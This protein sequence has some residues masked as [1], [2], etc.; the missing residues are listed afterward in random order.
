MSKGEGLTPIN[1]VVGVLVKNERFNPTGTYS[2]RASSVIASYLLSSGA[3]KVRVRFEE[4]FT[5]SLA[6][7]LDKVLQLEIVIDDPLSLDYSDIAVISRTESVVLDL[8]SGNLEGSYL[9]YIN[10]LTIEGLKTISLEIYERGVN[11]ERIVVPARTGFL[12]LSIWK[13]FHDLEELGL[14]VPY[15]VAAVFVK[16]SVRFLPLEMGRFVKVFEI[17][18]E[19]ILRT[20]VKLWRRGF[21]VK[22]ISAL[23]FAVSDILGNSLAIVTMG[24]KSFTRTGPRNEGVRREIVQVLKSCGEATAYEVWKRLPVLT[25]RGIYKVLNSM[26]KSGELCTEIRSRGARK[27]KYYKPCQHQT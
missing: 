6:Y 27:V 12:A 3:G 2:D 16:G 22:P 5:Y 11:V 20:L 14:D 25:L 9:S 1:R 8:D 18:G 7:Y 19:E 21:V 10:P 13:G 23:A 15:E 4:D 17:E 24:F 26:E